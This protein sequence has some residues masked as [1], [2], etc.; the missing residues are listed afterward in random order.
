MAQSTRSTSE[1][2]PRNPSKRG[3]PSALTRETLP[4][5]TKEGQK[6]KDDL[7]LSSTCMPASPQQNP[8]P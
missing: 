3:A 6:E 2:L 5:S 8:K 7:S 1:A 4:A